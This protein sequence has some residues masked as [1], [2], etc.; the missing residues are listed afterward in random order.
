MARTEYTRE[1]V[2]STLVGGLFIV[3]PVYLAVLLLLQGMKSAAGLVRP[4]A[5]LAPGLAPGRDALVSDPGAGAVFPR[6]CQRSV[7]LRGARLVSAWKW[8][9]SNGSLGT[10]CCAV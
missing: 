5:V 4:V 2:T 10:A 3:V 6:G 1:F 9:S 8:C 7:H